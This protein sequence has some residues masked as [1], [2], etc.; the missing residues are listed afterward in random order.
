MNIYV[1][2]L[3]F[4]VQNEDLKKLFSP[5]G[6]VSSVNI[7]MDKITN[8]SRGF[9]FVDMPSTESAEAAIKELNGVSMEG[10]S[11]KVNEAK[12]RVERTTGGRNFY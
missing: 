6:D 9:G 11:I 10:R 2:N 7:I 5:Y 12:P 1:S 4:G 3:G 8:R